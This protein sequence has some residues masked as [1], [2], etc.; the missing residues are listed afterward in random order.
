M[1]VGA[2]GVTGKPHPGLSY[3]CMT[4]SSRGALISEFPSKPCPV[5]IFT[6]HHFPPLVTEPFYAVR[7]WQ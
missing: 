6:T 3:E 7:L 2:P 5:G 4:K 1:T